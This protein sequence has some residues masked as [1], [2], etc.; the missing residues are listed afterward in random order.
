MVGLCCSFSERFIGSAAI[1]YEAS[2][3]CRLR[4]RNHDRG[5]DAWTDAHIFHSMRTRHRSGAAP[6]HGPFTNP[7]TQDG[8]S[9][10]GP[11]REPRQHTHHRQTLDHSPL[12]FRVLPPIHPC[13]SVVAERSR[14]HVFLM[15]ESNAVP[16]RWLQTIRI[17][18]SSTTESANGRNDCPFSNSDH[19]WYSAFRV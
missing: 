4:F 8:V 3:R 9:S 14:G 19:G 7:R 13:L 6:T 18:P 1:S 10:I 16:A 11:T 17:R 12:R 2:T 5:D 15:G